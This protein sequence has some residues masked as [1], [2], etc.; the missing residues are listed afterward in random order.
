[1]Y[2]KFVGLLQKSGMKVADVAKES[3]V[4]PSTFSDWK[5]GKSKPKVDKLQKIAKVFD[6]PV[7]YF[8]EDEKRE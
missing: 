6:V 3:G 8:I 1:M 7:S 5:S 4:S 2:S